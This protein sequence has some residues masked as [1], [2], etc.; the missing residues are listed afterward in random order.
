NGFF[1][2]FQKIVR[3]F[4]CEGNFVWPLANLN[5]NHRTVENIAYIN[6]TIEQLIPNSMTP[7]CPLTNVVSD[8]KRPDSAFAGTAHA[9][10]VTVLIPSPEYIGFEFVVRVRLRKP[11]ANVGTDMHREADGATQGMPQAEICKDQPI[12]VR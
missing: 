3:P 8:T 4:D 1:V 7:R 10:L 11:F 2:A 9:R 12:D 5:R 6:G